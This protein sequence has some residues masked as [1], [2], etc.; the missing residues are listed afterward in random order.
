VASLLNQL[1]KARVLVVALLF[2]IASVRTDDA[3]GALETLTWKE[4]IATCLSRLPQ[5]YLLLA[6][7]TMV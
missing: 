7:H 6:T 1:Y 4:I 2:G 5:C 3:A